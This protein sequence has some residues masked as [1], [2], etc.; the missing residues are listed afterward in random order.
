MDVGI[1]NSVLLI[2]QRLMNQVWSLKIWLFIQEHTAG[3]ADGVG[4][5]GISMVGPCLRP[6]EVII[7]FGVEMI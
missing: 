4:I 6:N 1:E 5:R 2:I 3:G 7:Q